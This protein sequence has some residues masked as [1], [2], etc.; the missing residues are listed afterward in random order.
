MTAEDISCLI[1]P[2]GCIGIPTLA[3]IEQ[4]IPVI[5]VTENKNRMKNDLSKYPFTQDK[6]YIVSSYL[7]AAGVML[8]LKNGV[9]VSSVKRPLAN[10]N[11]MQ[12]V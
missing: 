10:T 11:V 6:L 3:A 7:E 1:I 4:G 9:S 5:A 12:E 2:D 8:A